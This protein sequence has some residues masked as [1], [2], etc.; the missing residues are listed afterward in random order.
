VTA[1]DARTPAR[2]GA[3][4]RAA[5]ERPSDWRGAYGVAGDA[6]R[7]GRLG[8]A[9]RWFRRACRGV[10]DQAE[11]LN[12]LGA[13]FLGQGRPVLAAAP[14]RAAL[15]TLPQA[16]DAHLNLGVA[17]A[18]QGRAD[19][20]D[21]IYR[22]LLRLAPEHA[23]G[24]ANRGGLLAGRDQVGEAG[25]LL[26]GAA[27][28]QPDEG[29]IVN[30]L[31]GNLF[32]LEGPVA[33]QRWK[34]RALAIDPAHPGGWASLVMRLCYDPDAG[35]EIRWAASRALIA[36]GSSPAAPPPAWTTVPRPRDPDRPLRIGYVSADFANH[37]V[38]SSVAPLFERHDRSRVRVHAYHC[39]RTADLMTHRLAAAADGWR[40]VAAL[41]D[42]ALAGQVASDRIDILV[43][44]ARMTAGN[45]PL[46][47]LHRAAPIQVGLYDVASAATPAIDYWVGDPVVLPPGDAGERIDEAVVRLPAFCVWEPPADAPAPA[48][49]PGAGP[50]VIFGSLNNPSKL[51]AV[52]IGL[53]SRV[54]AAVPQA[55]LALKWRGLFADPALRRRV[56]AGFAT[57]GIAPDRLILGGSRQDSGRHLAILNRLDVMLDPTPYNGATATLE[58]LHMGVPVVTL[59]GDRFVG[60][61]AA[62]MLGAAGLDEL[63]A[64]TPDEYVAIATALA[65]DEG[66]RAAMRAS[67]RQRLAASAFCR[68]DEFVGCLEAAYREMWRRWCAGERAG[69]DIDVV[70]MGLPAAGLTT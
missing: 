44:L 66:R 47:C 36:S 31:S 37:T 14:L 23:R 48:R 43:M 5:L 40:D 50:A 64:R 26:R 1:A 68:V 27:I 32:L 49:A 63:V 28:L 20:A 67:L 61:I 57:H 30:L 70:T 16:P 10:A 25:W 60:R 24:R 21:R 52:T 45:R 29:R 34:R 41:D 12:G 39:G 4:R 69:G 6:R 13:S 3:A 11:V 9:I 17:L 33:G 8:E 53:W 65:R 18:T 15:A 46:L 42:A 19:E 55:R 35:P 56:E 7:R 38:A 22:R 51:N 59:R 2:H 54:L 58:A 62:S